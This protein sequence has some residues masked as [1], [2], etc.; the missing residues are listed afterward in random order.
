MEGNPPRKPL[1]YQDALEALPLFPLPQAVLMPGTTMPL[2]VFEPRYK[3]MV[4]DALDSHRS[5]AVVQ[6]IGEGPVDHVISIARLGLHAEHH[7]DKAEVRD[8]Q[9]STP[10]LA[11]L[12]ELL[13]VGCALILPDPGP[14][15]TPTL[16][17][18]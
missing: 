2:F 10:E 17:P 8:L 15:I 6:I 13:R 7:G 3:R 18:R 14:R 12:H 1:D 11:I 9:A 5:I 16:S 4:R